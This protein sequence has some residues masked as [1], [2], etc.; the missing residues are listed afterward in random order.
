MLGNF[1]FLNKKCLKVPWEK[2]TFLAFKHFYSILYYVPSDI[3]WVHVGANLNGLFWFPRGRHS[4]FYDKREVVGKGIFPSVLDFQALTSYLQS[5]YSSYKK[6]INHWH[7]FIRPFN[8]AL[9][10][11]SI[12]GT[13]ARF[14]HQTLTQLIWLVHLIEY[15][16]NVLRLAQRHHSLE[17]RDRIQ[18][19]ITGS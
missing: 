8:L 5:I 17:A 3:I 16:G 15:M 10:I 2:N 1:H 14:S 13:I 12:N 9:F 7:F 4:I 11:H 19:W 18:H 6:V